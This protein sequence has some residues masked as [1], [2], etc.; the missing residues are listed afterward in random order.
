MNDRAAN[1]DLTGLF[2]AVPATAA[3]TD[4]S[5]DS[6]SDSSPLDGTGDPVSTVGFSR[7]TLAEFFPEFGEG[8]A[9]E[10]AVIKS[11]VR[12]TPFWLSPE[13]CAHLDGDERVYALCCMA[14]HLIAMAAKERAAA[15]GASTASSTAPA[16]STVA[17]ASGVSGAVG[18]SGLIQSASVGGVSVSMQVPSYYKGSW[19][20]WLSQTPYGQ[21]LLAFLS[22]RVPV[23]IYG[24]GDDI[25]RCL[26]D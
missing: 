24:M 3:A 9:Y 14:G 17:S 25:R 16:G 20:W 11:A 19:D 26:R 6:G 5:A 1:Y 15:P 12:Q 7:E 2:G 23:A 18:G 10:E 8:S 21:R 13:G 4:G 22:S